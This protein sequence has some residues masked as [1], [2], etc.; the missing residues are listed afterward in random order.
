M[1]IVK[2]LRY[3]AY[4]L[5]LQSFFSLVLVSMASDLTAAILIAIPAIALASVSLPHP[6]QI[7]TAIALV[8]LYGLALG[9]GD[10]IAFAEN[11]PFPRSSPTDIGVFLIISALVA[12][13]AS[14]LARHREAA[15]ENARIANKLSHSVSELTDTN[16]NFQTYA[17]DAERRSMQEERLRITRE[18]HDV[19]GYT[20]TNNIMMME[21]AIDMVKKNP[22]GIEKLMRL[23]RENAEDGLGKIRMALHLLRAQ[24]DGTETGLQ[25]LSRMIGIF[26]IASG[27]KVTLDFCNIRWNFEP[28]VETL[29]FN[30]VR[31]ALT[32]SFWH[33][34][35]K[36]VKI[37]LQRPTD[38][39]ELVIWDDGNGGAQVQEGLGLKGIRERLIPFEGKFE[40]TTEFGGFRLKILLPEQHLGGIDV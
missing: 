38:G 10:R 14:G 3:F 30:T 15:I 5:A 24:E 29:L 12:L 35:A 33:G 21:A 23:S 31:E 9:M 25:A 40:A 34:K 2:G 19:I 13:L 17:F 16:L 27:S 37:Q 36:Q 26:E 8:C 7:F 6:K 22:E 28:A 18:I 20:L 11:F 32:N 4:A 1:T 39:L